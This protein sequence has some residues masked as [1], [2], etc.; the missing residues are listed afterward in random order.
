[1]GWLY[2]SPS[3][4]RAVHVVSRECIREKRKRRTTSSPALTCTAVGQL[5]VL[6]VS[7]MPNVGLNARFAMP[8]L[9]F[10]EGRSTIAVPVVSLPVPA[11]EAKSV[12][13]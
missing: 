2:N 12:D 4:G 3:R 11:A 9:K 10:R 5:A 1:M 8:V 13:G 7:T 6:S